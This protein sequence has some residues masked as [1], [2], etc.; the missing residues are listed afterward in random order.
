MS[1]LTVIIPNTTG[2]IFEIIIFAMLSLTNRTP[3]LPSY[4]N[5]STEYG[6]EKMGK[7]ADK[8]LMMVTEYHV[9]T[10][11]IKLH[12]I[13]FKQTNLLNIIVF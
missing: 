4:R 5:E 3:K 11:K 7:Q 1:Y 6:S 13:F 8:L 9:L 10:R 12:S 2:G